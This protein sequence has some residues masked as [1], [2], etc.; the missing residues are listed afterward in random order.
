MNIK[1]FRTFLRVLIN[2]ILIGVFVFISTFS[3]GYVFLSVALGE[4]SKQL[5]QT[6][7]NLNN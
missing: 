5:K 4:S 1:T 6:N 7:S 2:Y 3:F